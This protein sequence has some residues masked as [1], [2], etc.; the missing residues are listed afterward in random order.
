MHRSSLKSQ[1]IEN[2]NPSMLYS[3]EIGGAKT[4]DPEPIG[5]W[6]INAEDDGAQ[7]RIPSRPLKAIVIVEPRLRRAA[8]TTN[9]TSSNSDWFML[10]T[11]V[12]FTNDMMRLVSSLSS[13]VQI[14]TRM[15]NA[16]AQE[17]RLHPEREEGFQGLRTLLNYADQMYTTLLQTFSM[18]RP[19]SQRNQPAAQS[20]SLFHHLFEPIRNAGSRGEA[21]STSPSPLAERSRSSRRRRPYR[22]V[23]V[24]ASEASLDF[25]ADADPNGNGL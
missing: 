15:T 20:H 3:K 14:L 10:P 17:L 22:V 21:P 7:I 8:E 24:T 25:D 9:S 2:S 12:D 1:V 13:V 6:S 5:D 23:A 16:A 18:S 4:P 11:T 19:E